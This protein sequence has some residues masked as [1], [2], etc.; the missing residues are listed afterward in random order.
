MLGAGSAAATPVSPRLVTL[1]T[2]GEKVAR[3]SADGLR[4]AL[5][6]RT[7]E[8]QKTC[9]SVSLWRPGGTAGRVPVHAC[10]GPY[11]RS[12]HFRALTLAGVRAVWVNYTHDNFAYCEGPFTSTSRRLAPTSTRSGIC[13]GTEGN[14]FWDFA[15]D[16]HLLVGRTYHLCDSDCPPNYAGKYEEDVTLYRFSGGHFLTIA[17]LPRNTRLLGVDGGRILLRRTS[18][19]EIVDTHGASLATVQLIGRPQ[20]AFL[21][22]GDLVAAVRGSLLDFDS[23]TGTLRET[24]HLPVGGRL[25]GL[26][27]GRALYVLGARLHLLRLSDGQDQV[28]A[29]AAGLAHEA[30]T[31][32]GLY[33]ATNVAGNGTVTFVPAVRLPS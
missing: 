32:N 22:G 10:A 11:A 8:G 17:S 25:R 12:A 13:D 1:V 6:L 18:M 4:A 19:L 2:P 33:Y 16:G 26:E 5:L 21:S 20:A 24:W 9:R 27:D 28:V 15:G 23:A 3:L 31:A 30:L 7:S 14:Y 29:T